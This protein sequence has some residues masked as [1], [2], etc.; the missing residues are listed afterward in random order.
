MYQD[1]VLD[2]NSDGMRKII[3]RLQVLEQDLLE[4]AKLKH[5]KLIQEMNSK[6]Q[7]VSP[8]FDKKKAA[9][10]KKTLMMVPA[11]AEESSTSTKKLPRENPFAQPIHEEDLKSYRGKKASPGRP[12][13]LKEEMKPSNTPYLVKT[14]FESGKMT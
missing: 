1:T 3:I 13:K 4:L 11:L 14:D 2:L 9:L 12:A 8:S 7:K 5:Y 6:Q 10:K